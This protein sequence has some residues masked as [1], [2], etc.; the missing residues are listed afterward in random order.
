MV[1]SS[2]LKRN[3][4]LSQK[5]F[6]KTTLHRSDADIA[7]TERNPKSFE[8]FNASFVQK[9]TTLLASSVSSCCD[10]NSSN[11]NVQTR[12]ALTFRNAWIKIPS[13]LQR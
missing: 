9:Q 12:P 10:K 3:L 8:S 2:V 1:F 5:V 4:K 13:A 7:N 11:A 6:Q